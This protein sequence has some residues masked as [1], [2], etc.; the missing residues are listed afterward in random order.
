[1]SEKTALKPGEI[2][3]DLIPSD[4]PLTPVGKIKDPYLT[5]WQSNP[6]NVSEVSEH[7]Y[8]GRA[9]GIGLIGGPVGNG[10]YGL[11]WVDV[12]GESV[13]KLVEKLSEASFDAA[14]PHTLAI[15]SGKPGRIR[16]LYRVP[17]DKFEIFQRNKYVWLSVGKE[18]LEVLWKNTQGVL[19]GKHP[20]T[21]GYYTPE[22]EGFEHVESLPEIPEW[23]IAHIA[24]KNKKLGV[25][26]AERQR[27][28]GLNFAI[29]THIGLERDIKIA[30]KALA[31]LPVEHTEDYDAWISA[32]QALHSIDDT[33][34]E[35]W[36][37]WSQQSD[38]YRP[39]ECQRKWLTFDSQGGKGLGSLIA[40]AKKYGF[41][42][43]QDSKCAA[44]D[45]ADIEAAAAYLN[46]VEETV[47]ETINWVDEKPE[48][49][50]DVPPPPTKKQN[51]KQAGI[52]YKEVL[53]LVV[54]AYQGN[55]KFCEKAQKFRKYQ[56]S[57][58][59]K[60]LDEKELGK[61]LISVLNTLHDNGIIKDWTRRLADDLKENL[62]EQLCHNLWYE[63]RE[64][65][66]FTNGLLRV[67]D[68]KF[69]AIEEQPLFVK[70][71]YLIHQHPYPY[72]EGATCNK[73]QEWLLW[74]QH[75][76]QDRVQLLRAFMRAVLLQCSDIQK[77]LELVGY[78]K[79]GKS[80]FANLC[81]ALI[82]KENV[83][84]SN[85]REME[86]N[87]FELTNFVGKKLILMPD[88][89]RWG[90]SVQNL[91]ALT[92]HDPIR[93]EV[94]FSKTVSNFT[95][96]GLL[97]ITANAEIQTN[98]KSTGLQRRR[99]TVYMNRVYKGKASENRT[100]INADGIV[101]KGEFAD[102]LPGAIN[103]LLAMSDGEMRNYLM[104][105]AENVEEYRSEQTTR[106]IRVSPVHSW[107]HN[108]IVYDPGHWTAIGQ[109]RKRKNSDDGLD[110]YD[111]CK[112]DLYPNF[113]EHVSQYNFR[114]ISYSNFVAQ[115]QEICD[116]NELKVTQEKQNR[117]KGMTGLRLIS[118]DSTA[119][120]NDWP[121]IL[122][123]IDNKSKYKELY[124]K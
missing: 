115:L 111:A 108:N 28:V 39:G 116:T 64:Y 67:H 75:D 103:W 1:M 118:T 51:K 2:R 18:K 36:D 107:L 82:G 104:A 14:L 98:D 88:Q 30:E 10:E 38:K 122:D 70:N 114:A 101:P 69:M 33:C 40:E 17:R 41:T 76:K 49:E 9:R 97:I 83:A 53:D 32:G 45:D 15:K 22:G 7:I 63:E 52:G 123:Y 102:E 100:L 60:L 117:K 8:S 73:V 124:E 12:D 84:S 56:S 89:D 66:L 91:K 58:Y 23:I 42:V 74:T 106:D 24:A 68:M 50:E 48:V 93:G 6:L 96:K 44:V 27:Y 13:F 37:N 99:L 112:T 43:P 119:K 47:Q 65:L 62:S 92:G 19:M 59:W 71:L 72:V 29:N 26:H 79:T 34:L 25:P 80:T 95:Y 55:L 21:R 109:M 35:L 94:K 57:G 85:L 31:S 121:T 20:D 3:L 54:Q 81:V 113:L 78:G 87:K 77:F 120:Q 86:T 16:K 90:G 46:E 4:W 61:D 11:V 105:T 110:V 5:G